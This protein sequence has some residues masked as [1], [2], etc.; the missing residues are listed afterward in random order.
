MHRDEAVWGSFKSSAGL[1]QFLGYKKPRMKNC[2]NCKTLKKKNPKPN[3]PTK[4]T[5]TQNSHTERNPHHLKTRIILKRF[6]TYFYRLKRFGLVILEQILN[7]CNY[8]FTLKAFFRC[9]LAVRQ[10]QQVCINSLLI[11]LD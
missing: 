4:Q 2:A 5:K 11:T 9:E 8:F 6:E 1:C 10:K 7:C 3:Q